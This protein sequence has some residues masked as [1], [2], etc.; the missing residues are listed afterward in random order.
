[1]KTVRSRPK[2]R[3]AM[4]R[5]V[6]HWP[7]PVSVVRLVMPCFFG[8]IGLGDGRIQLV[9]AGGV[10]AFEFVVDLGRCAQRFFQIV[11]PDQRRWA[12]HLVVFQDF[13]R[14]IDET[15]GRCRLPAGRVPR[16]KPAAGRPAGPAS[17]CRDGCTDRAAPSCRPG[18]CTTGA[19]SR[20]QSDM[21]RYGIL[22][23]VGLLSLCARRWR[24]SAGLP[25]N[26][27]TCPFS[28]R[29]RNRF[30]RYHPNWLCLQSPLF[31]APADACPPG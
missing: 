27:K 7:A 4:A 29:D 5:A 12:E 31:H 17:W 26:K 3:Q 21:M 18:H 2:W 22:L 19:A 28:R 25:N 24:V 20:L 9:A 30:L 1:M 16:R 23:I 14:N 13:V 6:P 15:V 11:G 10:V 8:V